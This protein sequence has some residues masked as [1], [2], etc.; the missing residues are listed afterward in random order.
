MIITFM[1]TFKL[2]SVKL[3]NLIMTSF[4]ITFELQ[5][6]RSFYFYDDVIEMGSR[7]ESQSRTLT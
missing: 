2:E 7:L 1:Q 6:F 4:I 5:K 3:S